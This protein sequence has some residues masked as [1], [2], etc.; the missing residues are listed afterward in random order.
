[1]K[2]SLGLGIECHPDLE[3]SDIEQFTFDILNEYLSPSS[4]TSPMDAAWQFNNGLPFNSP[5]VESEE[6]ESIDCLLGEIWDL[7]FRL[8]QQIPHNHPSQERFVQFIL[9]LRDLPVDIKVSIGKDPDHLWHDLPMLDFGMEM[10]LHRIP[11]DH[12]F[13]D[14][15]TRQRWQNYNSFVARLVRDGVYV[16][17]HSAA[18]CCI[19]V[20]CSALED[21]PD[22][23]SKAY[24]AY[25][26]ELDVFLPIAAEWIL[27]AG[28]KVYS[29]SKANYSAGFY[30]NR[31]KNFKG[32]VGF[33][34]E[35][36]N[37]WK[38]RFEA[39]SNHHKVK[40]E[41]RLLATQALEAMHTAEESIASDVLPIL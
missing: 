10:W 18:L 39:V 26:P 38:G 19:S 6:M 27:L 13:T 24:K 33:S 4:S 8:A 29:L 34:V 21:E 25:G 35:R 15:N 28:K 37:F 9:A 5:D 22:P 20:L 36:W 14:D 40:D 1:M 31:G 11:T 23:R 17:L 12:I 2:N 3:P 30:G 32:P 7:V 41:T 16:G